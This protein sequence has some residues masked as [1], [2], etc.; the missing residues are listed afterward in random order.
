MDDFHRKTRSR[1][2]RQARCKP[3]NI[4]AQKRVH[5]ENPELC[6]Q[7][8]SRRARRLSDLLRGLLFDYLCQH[9][10]VDCGEADP[11][12]LDFDHVRGNKVANVS[13]LVFGLKKWQTVLDEIDKCEVVCANC[14]RR[15]TARRANSFRLRRQRNQ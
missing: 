11:V 6:R 10:C 2:G 1:D 9:P 7:R 8:I 13:A 4:A 15:R 3:C 12:V 14:H 5:A